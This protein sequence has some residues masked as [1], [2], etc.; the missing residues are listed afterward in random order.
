MTTDPTLKSLFISFEGIEGAGKSSLINALSISLSS[1]GHSVFC[2]REPGG[3]PL[4]EKIREILVQ[5]HKEALHVRSEA[6]LMQAARVQHVEHVLRPALENFDFILCDRYMDSSTVY[7]G[8]GRGLGRPWIEQLNAFATQEVQPQLTIV[9]D[10]PAHVSIE[11]IKT[12]GKAKDRFESESA[13]FFK[14][15]RQGYLDLAEH[16]PDRFQ[17]IDGMQTPQTLHDQA[18]MFIL[19]RHTQ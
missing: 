2:T 9:L 11:R 7:Q 12:R 6:L 5:P 15:L 10:I 14:T 18:L 1:K 13:D 8:I 16:A 19:Q 17:V 3:T 4:A